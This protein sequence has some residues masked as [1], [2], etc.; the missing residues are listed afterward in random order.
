VSAP[1]GAS[2]TPTDTPFPI[3]TSTPTPTACTIEF[4]DVPP[5][6][7]FYPYV[8]CLV[9]RGIVSGYADGTFRP[10]NEVTRGQ[11]SKVVANAA[12]FIE[13]IPN[14]IQTYEDVLPGTTFWSYIERLTS[15][16]LVTGYA[17]G[18]AV[19]EPCIPPQNRPYFRPSEGA[20]RG[21]VAKLASTAAGHA[22]TVPQEQ[23][24]Y[25]DVTYSN[26]FWLYIERLTNRGFVSGYA[27]STPN[28]PCVPPQNRPYFRPHART[29]RGQAA[30]IVAL[31]FYWHCPTP[32]ELR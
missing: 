4:S 9:C 32:A 19:D 11:L 27:C 8:R 23:Q 20:T 28:E 24:T 29:T 25:E 30:K 10:N 3:P 15:R 18:T 12:I 5:N 16:S 2:A 22:D 13:P 17:C 14:D 6:S 1:A 21:Q 31:T 26:P 7:T